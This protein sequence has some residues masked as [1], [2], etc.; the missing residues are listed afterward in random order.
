MNIYGSSQLITVPTRGSRFRSGI[1]ITACSTRGRSEWIAKP[2]IYFALGYLVMI[3]LYTFD[4]VATYFMATRGSRHF[5]LR[6]W[7][8]SLQK[9]ISCIGTHIACLED[10]STHYPACIKDVHDL[11]LALSRVTMWSHLSFAL[12]V[13]LSALSVRGYTLSWAYTGS[14][15]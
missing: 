12:A 8:I 15:S 2:A 3:A 1:Y 10:S 13:L 4:S 11:P 14:G 9:P 6:Y 7:L 5:H